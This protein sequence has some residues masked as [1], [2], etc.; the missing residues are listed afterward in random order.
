[1]Q[2]IYSIINDICYKYSGEIYQYIGDEVIISWPTKNT[3]NNTNAVKTFLEVEQEINK[4]S[5]YFQE[6]YSLTPEFW[7]GASSGEVTVVEIGTFKRHITYFG[8]ALN[9]ASRLTSLC[10]EAGPQFLI[11]SHIRDNLLECSEVEYTNLGKYEL[12]GFSEKVSVY[13]PKKR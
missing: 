2:E 5:N 1:M 6:T 8:D 13:S 11:S 12:R 9:M 3:E 4:R 7:S 10:K